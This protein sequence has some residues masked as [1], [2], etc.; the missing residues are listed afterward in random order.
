MNKR[1]VKILSVTI[2]H[3]IIACLVWFAGFW[4]FL[5]T[6]RFLLIK[7]LVLI[8]EPLMKLLIFGLA[9]VMVISSVLMHWLIMK[10]QYMESYQLKIMLIFSNILFM[11]ILGLVTL[12]YPNYLPEGP[13]LAAALLAYITFIVTGIFLVILLFSMVY[14]Y[15]KRSNTK[16]C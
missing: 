8:M 1:I 2:L 7:P 9:A 15:I 4:L 6:P 3:P 16:L 14:E 13:D 11:I 10:K 5:H 12:V